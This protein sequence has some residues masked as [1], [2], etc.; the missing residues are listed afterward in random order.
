MWCVLCGQRDEE[1]DPSLCEGCADRERA[2]IGEMAADP[3]PFE[4]S[5][6][7]ESQS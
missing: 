4:A 3:L 5:E 2:A 7:R 6:E 1:T